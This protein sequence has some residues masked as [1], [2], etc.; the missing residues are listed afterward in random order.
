MVMKVAKLSIMR[1][2][3]KRLNREVTVTWIGGE[4]T[5]IEGSLETEVMR[6]EGIIVTEEDTTT[7]EE[8]MVIKE[9]IMI[10]EESMEIE[11]IIM[12]EESLMIE[13]GENTG[14]TVIGEEIDLMI[15]GGAEIPMT[16]G[17]LMG[18]QAMVMTMVTM[19]TIV[20]TT[21]I[22]TIVLIINTVT[23]IF[24]I[25]ETLTRIIAMNLT[26]QNLYRLPKRYPPPPPKPLKQLLIPARMWIRNTSKIF[27]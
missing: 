27:S 11:G 3:D 12:I 16:T 21:I 13:E 1:L 25:Q 24:L 26:A 7:I 10:E 8:S 23:E 19:G 20:D 6:I 4:K 9:I 22:I 17:T 5:M 2:L 14:V 15:I 18:L